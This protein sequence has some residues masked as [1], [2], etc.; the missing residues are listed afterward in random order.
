M[1]K[2][3]AHISSREFSGLQTEEKRVYFYIKKTLFLL[4]NL[5]YPWI[6]SSYVMIYIIFIIWLFLL[7][8]Y[9]VV[10]KIS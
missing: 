6:T 1:M 10:F 9:Y 5:M 2:S 8:F 3:S 4:S 7:C